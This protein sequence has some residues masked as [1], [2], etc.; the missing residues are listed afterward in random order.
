M[1]GVEVRG[2]EAG[3]VMENEEIGRRISGGMRVGELGEMKGGDPGEVRLGEV[4]V[5]VG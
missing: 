3:N 5:N 1:R 2:R 4:R